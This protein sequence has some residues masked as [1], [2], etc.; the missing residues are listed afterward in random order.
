[1]V[2][3]D[4]KQAGLKRQ[5]CVSVDFPKNF[6]DIMDRLETS[7]PLTTESNALARSP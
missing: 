6:D 4:W 2:I 1:L 5:R 7:Y 3:D